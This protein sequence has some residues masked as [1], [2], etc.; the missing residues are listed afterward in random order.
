MKVHLS[1]QLALFSVLV[2]LPLS[3]MTA[4]WSSSTVWLKINDDAGGHDSLVFG[5][6]VLATYCTDNALGENQSPPYPPDGFSAVFMGIPSREKCFTSLGMIK[7]DLRDFSSPKKDT[8]DINFQNMAPAAQS[9]NVS[10]ILRWPGRSFLS[11]RCDSMFMVD[12]ADGSV[13]PNRIDMFA[14]D[15]LVLRGV[16]DTLGTN[17][18]SPSVRIR[19]LEYRTNLVVDAAPGQERI[20]PKH[21][22]LQQNYPNPFNPST[23]ISYGLPHRSHV[24]LT[25]YNLLGVKIKTIA[26]GDQ[27]A[28]VHNVVLDA[29]ALASGVY[30]YRLQAGEYTQTKKAVILK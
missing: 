30:Y 25:L 3:T 17:S 8:F 20:T 5:Y 4:Q 6:H 24:S 10:V 29:S 18:T 19:I 11:Q 23:T 21:F 14:Q 9:L 22:A 15:S 7:K 26:E 27:D 1:N 28:G 13:L 12:R 16:Y 2:I